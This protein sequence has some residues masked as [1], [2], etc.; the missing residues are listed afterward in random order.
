MQLDLNRD[1]RIG[2]SSQNLRI[3]RPSARVSEKY[4]PKAYRYRYQRMMQGLKE[5]IDINPSADRSESRY[6]R[7][8]ETMLRAGYYPRYW[9][10][11]SDDR[12]ELLCADP[13]AIIESG[14]YICFETGYTPITTRIDF[15]CYTFPSKDISERIAHFSPAADPH[16]PIILWSPQPECHWRLPSLRSP[17]SSSR[18]CGM[19]CDLNERLREETIL[20]C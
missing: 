3:G 7:I 11:S 1:Q 17:L 14:G 4:S 2:I 16:S 20:K 8:V 5:V 13:H 6:K 19:Y 15:R 9:R 10:W 12:P 18:V